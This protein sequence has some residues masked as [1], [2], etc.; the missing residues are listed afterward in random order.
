MIG[1]CKE[2]TFW[3]FWLWVIFFLSGTAPETGHDWMSNQFY[4]MRHIFCTVKLLV[5]HYDSKVWA[6]SDLC[7]FLYLLL[8]KAA[9]ISSKI[10]K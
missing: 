3:S 9:F 6:W 2:A 8:T 1:I 7:M 4:S 10:Q 5:E